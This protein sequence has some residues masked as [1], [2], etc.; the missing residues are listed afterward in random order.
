MNYIIK[1]KN[2][3]SM[4][5]EINENVY[6]KIKYIQMIHYK[7]LFNLENKEEEEDI[8]ILKNINKNETNLIIMNNVDINDN[9]LKNKL[10]N[11]NRKYIDIIY[12]LKS[13]NINGNLTIK[14]NSIMLN[15][16]IELIELLYQYF[17]NIKIIKNKNFN[18]F[19]RYIICENYKGI[20]NNDMKYY[21]NILEDLYYHTNKILLK[22]FNKNHNY[23]SIEIIKKYNNEINDKIY[24]YYFS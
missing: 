19:N 21:M 7:M 23:K 1:N 15:N 11:I 22:I 17:E 18:N 4:Y 20:P 14:I 24:N 2:K 16:S 3:I 9:K 12:C 6:S 10:I 8:E 13:L 5:N